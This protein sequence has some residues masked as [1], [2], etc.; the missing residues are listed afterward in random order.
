MKAKLQQFMMGRYGLDDL[1]R[2]LNTL[3]LVI[4]LLGALLFPQITGVAIG[5]MLLC[6]FRI[7]S[8]NTYKR[9]QEN[10]AYLRVRHKVTGKLSVQWQKIKSYK[11]HRFFRCPSCRQTL[12]VPKGKGTIT[13]TCPKCRTVFEKRS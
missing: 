3:V 13:V 10:A 6:Y 11:T 12:R 7:L 9:A 5:I 1:G 4:L 8:R 2:F